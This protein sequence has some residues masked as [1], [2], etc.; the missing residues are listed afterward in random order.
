M[1]TAFWLS[2]LVTA[3]AWLG[4]PLLLAIRVRLRPA[5][6]VRR[7]D[8][9]PTVSVV[10]VAH[11]EEANIGRKIRNC[12]EL[13]YP[14]DRLELIVASDGS[15]DRT[16]AIVESFAAEG[17][18]LLRLEGPAGKPT[19][20]NHA[21][22]A[23]NGELLL[24]C[25][26]RQELERGALR[27]LV[28]NFADQTVGAVSG[29]LHIR[30]AGGAAVE[31]VGFYW[32]FEKLVRRLESRAGSTVGVTG[33]I[34]ALRRQLYRPLDPGTI[35]DDVAIPM[36][37]AREGR[38]VVFEP[39]ARAWDVAPADPARE[40][41]RK[42]RTLAGNFQ[43]VALNPWLL[44]PGRNPLWWSFLSHKLSR[45]AVPW[46]ML[47]AFVACTGLALQGSALFSAA[48]GLQL[49]F[50]ALAAAG[51][52]WR[53]A[54]PRLLAVPSAL[55]LLNLAAAVALFEFLGGRQR[56]AWKTPA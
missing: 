25:D 40:F 33:A 10:I 15:R 17:V 50:Y 54:T 23:A 8:I 34:Y 51:W 20:L 4:Y 12:L 39:G 32:R 14:R 41:R 45:L 56:A 37:V 1:R 44:V 55:V 42:V 26:A 22:P 52:L 47:A 36:R 35:L 21:A 5:P 3:Y 19:A 29:E 48:A 46:C 2:A 28:A 38:R 27:E 6:A 11:D 24:L 16:D 49:A 30:P 9:Q 43:L 31:G 18:R 13:D 7:A 53:G